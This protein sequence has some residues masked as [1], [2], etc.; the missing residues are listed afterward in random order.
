MEKIVI[1]ID[2]RFREISKYPNSEHFILN[3]NEQYKNIDF[4]KVATVEIPN[5]FYIFSATRQSNYFVIDSAFGI[6]TKVT[7]NEG[8]YNIDTLIDEINS[9][10]KDTFGTKLYELDTD[11]KGGIILGKTGSGTFNVDFSN[12]TSQYKSL[13]YHLGFRKTTYNVTDSVIAESLCDVN[14]ENYIFIKIN[15][16][17]N[18]IINPVLGVKALSKV[19][20]HQSKGMIIFD[21]NSDMLTKY[22][23][24]R[25]PVNIKRLEIELLDAYGNRVDNLNFDYSLTLEIG[26]IYRKEDYLGKLNHIF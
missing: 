12:D 26:Q 3:L 16:Y 4:I 20:L 6:P 24:F 14:G 7:I 2:S 22:Y 13:G 5:N 23:I 10:I 8:N 11:D 19:V 18:L 25:Q 17:G 9:K 1:N 15:D 21:N